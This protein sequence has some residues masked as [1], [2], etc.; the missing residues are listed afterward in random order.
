MLAAI[1]VMMIGVFIALL[2][3]GHTLNTTSGNGIFALMGVVVNASVIIITYIN[4]LR[5]EGMAMDEAIVAAGTRRLRPILLTVST[6]FFAMLPM[7]L[8]QAE[9]S[10]VYK[11][12][13]IAFMGGLVT[14]T[15]LTLILI[16]VL[17]RIV[18]RAKPAAQSERSE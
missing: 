15:I 6:T 4:Q 1:P 3:T 13:A 9:G 17:Y 18:V 16:P 8:S 5:G 14:S 7:A 12:L 11:P 10:D 2:V